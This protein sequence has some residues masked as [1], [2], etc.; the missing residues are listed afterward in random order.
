MGW[1]ARQQSGYLLTG[2]PARLEGIHESDA[3]NGGPREYGWTV[4]KLQRLLANL[5]VRLPEEP[6]EGRVTF[7][8]ELIPGCRV[9]G[10]RSMLQKLAKG[11]YPVPY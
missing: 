1:A 5:S 10:Y 3:C 4:P 11:Y 6:F 8:K 9:A 7:A 2:N